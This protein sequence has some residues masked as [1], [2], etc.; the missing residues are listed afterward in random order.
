[1]PS[2]LFPPVPRPVDAGGAPSAVLPCVLSEVDAE[3]IV[4]EAV[5]GRALAPA[6][7]DQA[8][9][10][11]PRLLAVPFWRIEVA[12]DGFHLG[13]SG[14]SVSVGGAKVPIPTGGS[15]H[16]DAALTV[17][18]RTAF[19]YEARV[20]AWIRT[21]VGNPP[22]E[23]A[24]HELV[25]VEGT[26]PEGELVD[27]DLARADAERAAVKLLVRSVAPQNA[28]YVKVEPTVVA[29]SFVRLPVYWSSYVYEGEAK[30]HG[31]ER[32]FVAVSGRDGKIVA[33][34]HPSGL[35]AAAARFRRLLGG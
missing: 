11:E 28:L 20:P 3:V 31:G 19:P 26:R 9:I 27:A 34:H 22:I 25:G 1:M 10:D 15:R 35:R 5:T 23:I 14:A 13:L 30:R 6:D 7:A 2:P 16:K 21:V 18:A 29:T 32:F 8:R 4:R 17:C 24:P 33:A 12:V